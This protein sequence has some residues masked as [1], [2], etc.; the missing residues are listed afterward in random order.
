[1]CCY[2]TLYS[3]HK[4]PYF[5]T[6]EMGHIKWRWKVHDAHRKNGT[7]QIE[8][9]RGRERRQDSYSVQTAQ[10]TKRKKVVIYLNNILTLAAERP[11]MGVEVN[12]TSNKLKI[13]RVAEEEFDLSDCNL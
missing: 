13:V 6:C 9:H 12:N 3:A 7:Y 10:E 8:R 5:Y 2:S 1:M 4:K 11:W